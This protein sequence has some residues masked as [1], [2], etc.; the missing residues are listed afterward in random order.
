M[1]DEN[2]GE[3][4]GM[5]AVNVYLFIVMSLKP[6]KRKKKKGKDLFKHFQTEV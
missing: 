1:K 5:K 2:D 3:N 4:D 6:H